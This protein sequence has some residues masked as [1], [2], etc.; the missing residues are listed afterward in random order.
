[1]RVSTMPRLMVIIILIFGLRSFA[2]AQEMVIGEEGKRMTLA[3]PD[4]EGSQPFDVLHY[5]LN[6]TLPLVD[7]RLFGTSEIT[8]RLKQA[9]DSVSLH[10][11]GL[12]IDSVKIG[13]TPVVALLDSASERMTVLL[14]A[15][16][17]AGDTI[18]LRIVYSRIQNYPRYGRHGYYFFLDTLGIPANLGYT[19]S[20]PSDARNW[21]P[22][23]DEPWEKS[24]AEMFLTVPEGFMPASNGL[25]QSSV[26]NGDGTTT[27]HWVE[28]N[29]ITTYLMCIT[30]S[31]FSVST[32]PYFTASNDTIPIQY[33]VWSED[34]L[35]CAA[36]LP[37]V[38]SMVTEYAR[39]FGE[40]PFKK[41][42][43][44]A[45][46]PFGPLGMEHQSLTTL[47]RF[48]KTSRWVVS[49]ELAHQ[50]WGDLV[51][52]GTWPDVWLNESFATYSEAL[53]M[54]HVGGFTALKSYMKDTL[55][56]FQFASWQGAVYDPVGQG[57]NLFDR[58]VY[59]KGG[60][61]LHMLRRVLG[62]SMFFQSLNAYRERYSGQ[63]AI[64]AEFQAVVDS[65][66]E[67]NLSWFFDQWIFGR[68]WP[69]YALSSSWSSDTITATIYQQQPS[70]WPVYKMPITVRAYTGLTST[71]FLLWDSVDVQTFR[72]PFGSQPDSLVFDPD[73]W[74][75]K[76]IVSPPVNVEVNPDLPTEF[77]LGQNYPNPF[78]PS[79]NIKYEIPAVA[80]VTI[81]VYDV[82][83]SEVATLVD[84]MHQPGRYEVVWD[85]RNVTSGVYLY[86]LQSGTFVATK[87]MVLLH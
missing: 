13:N 87:K 44:T 31:R 41:Y 45:I 23:Y 56:Q 5:K 1:M 51:T 28:E 81:K 15:P 21:M 71:D 67:M 85:A 48:F 52:C 16:G 37:T 57:F 6:L 17:N 8:M 66:T 4:Y 34:S 83:G 14:P 3:N 86:R 69:R 2:E 39:L 72:L 7:N 78:N 19:F 42:G 74:V 33:Y 64:T 22:C 11:V 26:N 77:V 58:V 76:Q 27:W 40:Y 29:Q 63:S 70:T 9:I 55:T 25:L 82:L 59:S 62:D 84:G 47:N 36:Y 49:H 30:A 50:W 43:M 68:G 38:R 73:Y 46:V 75:L 10:S 18:I 79:T 35:E 53:W 61:V 12:Q 24:A 65:V 60:W 20:E 54:E 32:L 80:R